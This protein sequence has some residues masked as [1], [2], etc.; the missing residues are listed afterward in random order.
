MDIKVEVN[1]ELN[2]EIFEESIQMNKTKL[3]GYSQNIEFIK[4]KI[5]HS[6]KMKRG[7]LC[8]NYNVKIIRR[9][10]RAFLISAIPTKDCSL[11]KKLRSMFLN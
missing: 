9:P 4:R 10:E 3:G 7:C 11:P 1:E 8:L 5:I 6:L 2:N